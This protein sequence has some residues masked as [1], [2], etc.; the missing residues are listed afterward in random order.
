MVERARLE[1]VLRGNTYG[2]S[3]PSLCAI[4]QKRVFFVY[5]G[6]KMRVFLFFVYRNLPH[7]TLFC[8]QSLLQNRM[9]PYNYER[10]E[11]RRPYSDS[12][13]SLFC[14]DYAKFSIFLT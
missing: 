4:S 12:A 1:I 10:Q 8:Y 14:A 13:F 7:F 9:S 11:M 2:G 6:V 3:N 5:F